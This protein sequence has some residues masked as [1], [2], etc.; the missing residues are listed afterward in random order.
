MNT[1]RTN[2][3]WKGAQVMDEHPVQV[4]LADYVKQAAT[5]A[6]RVVIAEH[7]KTCP[8]EYLSDKV[9]AIDERVKRI[10]I[11]F[12]TLIGLMVGSGMCGGAVSGTL[13]HLMGG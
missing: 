13:I 4:P 6:A 11:R 2:D 8:R 9:N 5:T 10:E 3:E 7:V 12:A 1:T